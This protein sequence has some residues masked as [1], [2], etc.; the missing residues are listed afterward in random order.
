VKAELERIAAALE[1][2]QPTVD[3]RVP[4]RFARAAPAV[5]LALLPGVLRQFRRVPDSHV[6]WHGGDAA[7]ACPCGQEAE[8]ALHEVVMCSCSRVFLNARATEVYVA[9]SPTDATVD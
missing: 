9:N 7:V 1:A 8:V 4:P 5:V 2:Q 3:D 6:G